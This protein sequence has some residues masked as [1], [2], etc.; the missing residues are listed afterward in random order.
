MT[1]FRHERIHLVSGPRSGVPVAV[2]VH[3]TA[4]GPAVGGCRL[5]Q[6]PTWQDGL[7]DALRL[8]E[9]MTLKC[10]VAGL[11]H[12]GGKTV[13]ALEPGEQL[14]PD[15]RRAVML[16]VGDAVQDLHGAY[17]IGE[18]V[19]TT[20]LDM[21]VVRE[22]TPHAHCLPIELGG[23]GEPSLPTA[24]GVHAAIR[25]TCRQ[26]F[27]QPTPRGLRCTVIGLGQVGSRLARLLL[28]DGAEV[29][30]TDIDPQRQLLAADLGMTWLDPS[31]ALEDETD[32][33]VPAALGGVLTAQTVPRL[34]CRAIVGPANNQL[35]EEEVVD[36]LA[37]RGIL[38]APDFVANAGGVVYGI[39][40]EVTGLPEQEALAH[41]DRIGETMARVYEAADRDG[42]T[43][44]AAALALARDRVTTA[45]GRA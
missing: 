39:G 5:W 10:A 42:T 35:F 36:L 18:D 13:I 34:R 4:L 40:R 12:G 15:R 17:R 14:D 20:A 30:C 1:R 43:P 6:Y 19:G 23:I 33:L 41:V 21:A 7:A 37:R 25:A 31:D 44:Y 11:D 2:A 22:R 27:D 3:S 45:G 32:L 28:D 16:D 26:V 38:W 24:R 29:R 9:A 8:S